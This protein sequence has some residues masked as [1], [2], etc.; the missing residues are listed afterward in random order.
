MGEVF[1]FISHGFYYPRAG[2]GPAHTGQRHFLMD[3][4]RHF[5]REFHFSAV[6][7]EGLSLFQ[8]IFTGID[9][10]PRPPQTGERETDSHGR[11]TL[12]PVADLPSDQSAHL[13]SLHTHT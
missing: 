11:V 9:R 8:W 2:E 4:Q 7:S 5:A 1:I 10:D 13:S 6:R 3:F 12:A